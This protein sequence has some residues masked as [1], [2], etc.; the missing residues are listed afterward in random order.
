MQ[1]IYPYLNPHGFK[2]RLDGNAAVTALATVL[3]HD[4]G[5]V[6][7]LLRVITLQHNLDA[8]ALGRL[9]CMN[10]H[11]YASED[12]QTVS[13]RSEESGKLKYIMYINCRL[14]FG[15]SNDGIEASMS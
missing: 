5:D 14:F 4:L 7:V 6:V 3:Y 9:K 13:R 11:F 2:R 10:F 12:N 8:V 15:V 1:N